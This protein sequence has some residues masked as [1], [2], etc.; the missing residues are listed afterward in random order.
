LRRIFDRQVAAISALLLALDPFHI[1]VSQTLHVDALMSVFAMLS[2]L[3]MLIHI[4]DGRSHWHHMALSGIFAGLA[5]LSKAPALFLVPYLL[6]S[7]GSWQLVVLLEAGSGR[8]F[9]TSRWREWRRAGGKVL[10]AVLIWAL[11]AATVYF[12][13]WP[14]MWVQPGKT[15]TL[16]FSQTRH[17]SDTPHENPL[18]FLG[19]TTPEDPGGLY[20]PVHI[21]IKT[22]AVTLPC[23]LLGLCFLFSRRLESRQRLLLLLSVAFIVF[24]T[25]QMT[26]GEKKMGRYILPALQFISV[27]AGFG[28][29]YAVRCLAR[30]HRWVF[31]TVLLLVIAAQVA[32]TA[33][34]HPYYGTHY[35]G[36]FGGARAVLAKGIV[37]GQEQGEGLD[38]AA[39]YLN[40][41]PMSSLLVV[42]SQIDEVFLKY[43]QGK[44]VPLTDDRVDY[45]VFARNWVVRGMEED[46]WGSVWQAYQNRQP[47]HVVALDGVPYV[48]VYKVGPV[49]EE[50][51]FSHPVYADIGEDFHLLGYD[52]EPARVPAGGAIKL[53]L[54]WE[55]VHG[56]TGDYTVFTHLLDP[57]GQ[58]RSQKD[59]QPQGGMYPTFLWDQ[60]ERILDKY[61]LPVPPDASPGEYKI[62]LGMYYLPTLERLPAVGSD[63][64]PLPDACVLIPGP[65]VIE[66]PS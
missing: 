13:L 32:I 52:L 11:A 28:V 56:S 14:S 27:V 3:W 4:R 41:Y 57:D 65:Q 7:L 19:E 53:T 26:L 31:R 29:V 66:P 40:R 22:T 10:K 34:S 50:T 20:Y 47:K 58:V 46:K 9:S 8:A 21:A 35:N 39:E 49:I 36:L 37:A 63:G 42:G 24:F 45:L 51:T 30:R 15:L 44:T 18:L 43:F 62:A 55:A 38:I 23:F 1:A 60:G 33:T 12:L 64:H 61:V 5:L 6:L 25:A 17:Y 2:A 16:V 54:Y 59:N 48:W